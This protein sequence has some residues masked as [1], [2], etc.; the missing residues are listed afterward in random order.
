MPED[1]ATIEVCVQTYTIHHQAAGIPI[2]IMSAI[3]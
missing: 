3:W 2:E 1:D